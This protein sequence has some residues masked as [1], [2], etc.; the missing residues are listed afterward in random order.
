MF[1]RFQPRQV[2][3]GVKGQGLTQQQARCVS[4]WRF[5]EPA[6]Q[7]QAR[8][9]LALNEGG[10]AVRHKLCGQDDLEMEVVA[11]ETLLAA[12]RLEPPRQFI[13]ACCGDGEAAA[14]AGTLWS[15]A[16]HHE[17]V[18]LE[19]RESRVHLADVVGRRRFPK[20]ALEPE[21]Q[22]VPVSGRLRQQRKQG[23]LHGRTIH[24]R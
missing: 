8:C 6:K 17:A 4:G 21:L 24:T 13:L 11:S 14:L 10:E 1:A 15:V 22:L 5:L 12:R 23:K 16:A 9:P 3:F 7:L 18:P 19:P 2:S 20:R